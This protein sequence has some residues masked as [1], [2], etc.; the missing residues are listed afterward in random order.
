VRDVHN[1]RRHASAGRETQEAIITAWYDLGMGGPSLD[2]N[3]RFVRARE[4][5][6]L[7]RGTHSGTY[8]RVYCP[9]R[10]GALLSP[11]GV[12]TMRTGS[13]VAVP[14]G[15]RVY[16]PP[17]ER[18]IMPPQVEHEPQSIRKLYE[19]CENR[20][21][22][23]RLAQ[24]VL[25]RG[26]RKLLGYARD[27]GYIRVSVSRRCPTGNAGYRDPDGNAVVAV[28]E[29]ERDVATGLG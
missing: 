23:L 22:R 19:T 16:Y 17:D 2:R 9:P 6:D 18:D 7:L 24:T 13:R 25:S 4:T 21:L 8:V 20:S 1:P 11:T 10:E 15:E 12:I 14:A 28:E 5:I 3:D 29:G 26:K 27:K